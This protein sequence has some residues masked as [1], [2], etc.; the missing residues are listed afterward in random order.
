MFL[1]KLLNN[2]EYKK[3]QA[4]GMNKYYFQAADSQVEKIKGQINPIATNFK[5]VIKIF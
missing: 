2:K 3:L 1:L 4:P 5:A